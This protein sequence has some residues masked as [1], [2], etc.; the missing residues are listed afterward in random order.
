MKKVT[1]FLCLSLLAYHGGL[2]ETGVK[3]RSLRGDVRIRRGLE[4]AWHP[5]GVGMLL[6]DIDTI[7]TGEASEVLLVL[8]EGNLFTLGSNS[9]MDIGDLRKIT[10]RELFLYLMS[11]KLKRIEKRGEKSK[12]RIENISVVRAERKGSE[13]KDNQEISRSDMWR[14]E[15]NGARALYT[16][17]YYP[18]TVVKL[19]KVLEK[20]SSMDD[21]GEIHF[22]IGKSFEALSET[23]RAIDAY[24]Q[25][26]ER[27]KESSCDSLTIK[28]FIDA[29]AE[30]IRR[31]KR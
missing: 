18:N 29:S 1:L 14:R 2:T 17:R 27:T 23:G 9:I 19:Y 6:E 25:V 24:Q 5:A 21:C 3:V 26:L 11:Q 20:Y 12:L 28:E 7:L 13:I 30:A 15:I 22:Y 4:E 10:E 31:L 16:Q 8:V